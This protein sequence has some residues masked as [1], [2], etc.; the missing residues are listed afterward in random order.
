MKQ[1]SLNGC[2]TGMPSTIYY[3]SPDVKI[4]FSEVTCYQRIK[5][6]FRGFKYCAVHTGVESTRFFKK[7][8][9]SQ[10]EWNKVLAV[11]VDPASIYYVQPI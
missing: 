1:T 9:N 3:P 6:A 5:V 10:T 2:G 4:L 8:E 11:N 7:Q